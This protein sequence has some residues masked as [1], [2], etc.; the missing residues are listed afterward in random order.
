MEPSGRQKKVIKDDE[1]F[2]VRSFR[3]QTHTDLHRC[4]ITAF[5]DT[6]SI[7]ATFHVVK[8]SSKR[9][10]SWWHNIN[11]HRQN[12]DKQLTPS[13]TR[14]RRHISDAGPEHGRHMTWMWQ[15]HCP[16]SDGR[17]VHT[18]CV[19]AQNLRWTVSQ[20]IY[21]RSSHS[22][23]DWRGRRRLTNTTFFFTCRTSLLLRLQVDSQ[24][25][26]NNVPML[27]LYI[28][29]KEMKRPWILFLSPQ[30]STCD[31]D[32]SGSDRLSF[33]MLS[34]RVLRSRCALNPVVL[35]WLLVSVPPAGPALLLLFGSDSESSSSRTDAL[36]VWTL[37]RD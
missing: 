1:E 8:A 22:E 26:W 5:M 32:C 29:H 34:P 15:T 25:T 30:W 19:C 28:E 4:T 35:M 3:L 33:F 23:S 24:L 21:C 6:V 10:L 16:C 9:W 13:W 31:E 27:L 20:L 37:R 11:M 2:H 36:C 14:S 7:G 18:C 17:N 12:E